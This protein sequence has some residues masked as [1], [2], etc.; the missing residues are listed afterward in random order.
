MR[1]AQLNSTTQPTFKLFNCFFQY[2]VVA[3]NNIQINF[4]FLDANLFSFNCFLV[5]EKFP[6]IGVA[7]EK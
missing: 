2:Q 1:A 7:F 6:N 3:L 5:E 4:T